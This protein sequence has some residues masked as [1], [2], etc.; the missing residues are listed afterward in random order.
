MPKI[1]KELLE[2]PEIKVW[3]D[4]YCEESRIAG[5]MSYGKEMFQHREKSVKAFNK[6]EEIL[7]KRK[8]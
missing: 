3:Y 7:E 5:S 6:I 4:E 2:D 1:A 8:K